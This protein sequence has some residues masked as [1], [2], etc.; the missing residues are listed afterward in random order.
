MTGDPVMGKAPNNYHP[1]AY[2]TNGSRS[3][4]YIHLY[5]WLVGSFNPVKHSSD[6]DDD[7]DDDDYDYD[8]EYDDDVI[9]RC[10]I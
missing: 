7:K 10:N 6:D 9:T 2:S 4:I 1:G 8:Y 5:R 3:I